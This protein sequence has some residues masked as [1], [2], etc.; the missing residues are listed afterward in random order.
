MKKE[1]IMFAKSQK[2][3]RR[4]H[5]PPAS[6]AIPAALTVLFAAAVPAV[7]RPTFTWSGLA[8][9]GSSSL[10]TSTNWVGNA[11]PFSAT[12]TTLL[13]NTNT[14]IYTVNNL[15][16]G[17][18]LNSLQFGA[19]AG[20]FVM[21]MLYGTQRGLQFM[22]DGGIPPSVSVAGTAPVRSF[23]DWLGGGSGLTVNIGA[24]GKFT[25]SGRVFNGSGTLIKTGAGTFDIVTDRIVSDRSFTDIQAGTLGIN[26]LYSTGFNFASV[27]I[28]SGA[29]LRADYTVGQNLLD[30][31]GSGSAGNFV[32]TRNQSGTLNTT[33][34]GATRY[35][36]AGNVIFSGQL[37]NNTGNHRLG[38]GGGTLT[39]T[40]NSAV[41]GNNINIDGPGKIVF[42]GNFNGANSITVA[43]GGTVQMNG[44]NTLGTVTGGML[45]NGT[46]IANYDASSNLLSMING[47]STGT[48]LLAQNTTAN[49]TSGFLNF[50]VNGGLGG[51]RLG[52][53]G[54]VVFTGGGVIPAN[55]LYRFGG[56]GTLTFANSGQL[57]NFNGTTSAVIESGNVIYAGS[58]SYTGAT[59]INSGATLRLNVPQS[60]VPNVLINSGAALIYGYNAA[61][62]NI[63]NPASVGEVLFGVN[64]SNFLNFGAGGGG[65]PNLP[66]VRF[67]ALGNVTLSGQLVPAT[68]G[69]NAFEYKLGGGGGNLTLAAGNALFGSAGLNVAGAGKVVLAGA[70]SYTGGT[71]VSAGGTL[72]ANL[73]SS[74][75]SG[76]NN[77][78]I[79]TG[80]T[81]IAGFAADNNL[82]A[83]IA[84]ASAGTLLLGQN[85]SAFLDLNR[86][87]NALSNLKL[88]ADGNVSYT[89][90]FLGAA[91]TLYR[92]GGDGTL[93]FA[94][95][96]QLGNA[97]GTTGVSIESGT[98]VYNAPQS[99]SGQTNILG[100]GT[101]RLN[102]ST[103]GLT[104]QSVIIGTGGTLIYGSANFDFSR[105]NPAS[106][107]QALF[108]V[109]TS[110]NLN[111][112]VFGAPNLPNV[113][114]GALGNVTLGGQL[115]PADT[116]GG[117]FHY[118]L[119][120]GGGQLTLTSTSALTGPASLSVAG[121]GSV[122]I[123]SPQ[124]YTGATSV[125]GGGTLEVN[126]SS[127]LGS[128]NTAITLDNGTLR[129]GAAF[130]T[131]RP[132]SLGAGGGTF[133]TTGGDLTL[134]MI[135]NGQINGAQGRMIKTGAGTLTI[136]NPNNFTQTY[137]GGTEIRGGTL[138]ISGNPSVLFSG[139]DNSASVLIGQ[140]GALLV[141]GTGNNSIG[142]QSA[143]NK[144]DPASTGLVLLGTN[145]PSSS[146]L[147]LGPVFSGALNRPGIRLGAE[148]NI[149]VDAFIAPAVVVA[150]GSTASLAP[151][152]QYKLGGGS[153]KLTITQSGA[154]GNQNDGIASVDIAGVGSTVE[155]T[156]NNFYSGGTLVNS[157]RLLVNNGYSGSATGSG[158]V[159]LNAGSILG[160][161]GRVDGNVSGAGMDIRPGMSPG[162]LDIRGNLAMDAASVLNIEIGGTTAGIGNGFYDLLLVNGTAAVNGSLNVS[163]VNGF[164]PVPGQTFTFL[165]SNGG[166]S[167]LFNPVFP[168]VPG[169]SL[170]AQK[171]GNFNYV[172]FAT[173]TAPSGF[174]APPGLSMGAGNAVTVVPETGV[175]QLLLLGMP[176]AGGMAMRRALRPRRA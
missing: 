148:G 168:A 160:G 48:I 17:F 109:D 154:L 92:F 50:T 70:N 62:F 126:S 60:G 138:A 34:T 46:L 135:A 156:N 54:S 103:T 117:S 174:S 99:Y 22:D 66:N 1:D 140:N 39:F 37:I 161:N 137:S 107:G 150:A 78:N 114:F 41:V 51:V 64:N 127:A 159:V 155:L 87:G 8:T 100:G 33:N 9:N 104:T 42:A 173:S 102:S 6:A 44:A 76:T 88:G 74:L 7:A 85:T 94:N 122:R 69:A 169:V 153:G 90:S 81:L 141:N 58:Q 15:A 172:L 110:N 143:I 146:F 27:L 175:V 131:T 21:T 16:N 57:A 61:D 3:R 29:T 147:A 67:G 19:D 28:R 71:T 24:G 125:T 166:I 129:T 157:G 82:L 162:I 134:E 40:A 53:E 158:P 59:T 97:S 20:P 80:G 18:Q 133:D 142:V 163:F 170:S 152:Y 171:V 165:I 132:F 128:G 43:P 164:L 116:G 149:Q 119:G 145:V 105:V 13:F 123:V 36:A 136:N 124:S 84:P 89:G 55:N 79:Q 93:T 63:V 11:T 130:T 98:V 167:G 91:G 25:Q 35:G 95:S 111:F 31:I 65:A 151:E 38:A 86:S 14:N 139:S 113:R 2:S 120:G 77:V 106:T 68:V 144:I 115:F 5:A 112:G 101:L 72:Q 52:A 73:T 75:G 12:N 121:T 30:R 108:A 56:S 10:A 96:G 83:K 4:R 23:V 49:A 26:S 32:F 118:K 47:G 176:L 45:L